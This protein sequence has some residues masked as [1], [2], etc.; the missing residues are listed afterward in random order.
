MDHESQ[1]KY[2][3]FKSFTTSF[4]IYEINDGWNYVQ[5]SKCYPALKDENTSIYF[6]KAGHLLNFYISHPDI[7]T[8]KLVADSTAVMFN[9]IFIGIDCCVD[10]QIIHLFCGNSSGRGNDKYTKAT[11]KFDGKNGNHFGYR[12]GDVFLILVD[13][14]DLGKDDRDYIMPAELICDTVMRG[15][16]MLI[17]DMDRLVIKDGVQLNVPLERILPLYT[18]N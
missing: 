3:S 1:M 17:S 11:I 15:Q 7:G 16:F 14:V 5:N 2:K 8:I 10:K 12:P 9:N 4:W 13:G 18:V 6:N